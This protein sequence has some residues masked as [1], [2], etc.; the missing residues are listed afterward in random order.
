MPKQPKPAD[1][2][3]DIS[4]VSVKLKPLLGI[5][6]GAY[7]TFLY[8]LVGA[9]LLFLLLFLPGIRRNGTLYTVST[10]PRGAA[11]FVDGKYAGST[12][13]KAFVQKGEHEVTIRRK[14]FVTQAI[15]ISTRGRLLGSLFV[16]R[17]EIISQSLEIDTLK[18]L[19]VGGFADL[20]EWALVDRFGP[21]YQPPY[22]I[23]DIINDI[24]SATKTTAS[25][26]TF[27][28]SLI[29]EFLLQA[30]AAA[31]N[32]ITIADLVRGTLLHESKGLIPTPDTLVLG[33]RRLAVLKQAYKNLP[34]LIPAVLPALATVKYRES[35]WFL[36]TVASYRQV[37]ER[38]NAIEPERIRDE[39]IIRGLPFVRVPAGEFAFGMPTGA[40]QSNELPHP[41]SVGELYMLKGEVTR[42][43]YAEFVAQS[44][45]WHPDNKRDLIDRNAVDDQ[46]LN[47]F[48]DQLP[49]DLPVSFVSYN[50]AQAF[51]AW[52]ET[53]L[54]E[55]WGGF[56]VR[57]PTEVEW[58]WAAKLS[59]T[60]EEASGDL[61]ADGPAPLQ[62]RLGVEALMGSLWEWC[63][64]WYQ[65]AAYFLSSWTPIVEEPTEMRGAE[66]VVR[67]GS[68]VNRTED[69]ISPVTRGSQPPEW[70]T[71]FTGFRIVM[72]KK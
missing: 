25:A 47:D 70:C 4:Q 53:T 59:S 15:Q 57:L 32:P 11:V 60:E 21:S 8:V 61:H 39:R 69:R 28:A 51:A 58:E 44:P 48:P 34:L 2:L 45:E 43:A 13:T 63:V 42:D 23:S 68:W 66:V 26:A 24:Y 5:K 1:E 55:A 18:E 37:L 72:V 56:E 64:T 27:D 62:G 12:P 40:S 9:G 3:E 10:V 7:L 6:P 41:A 52:F 31:D 36:E 14:Y 35:D 16:P 65:P 46:Y 49:G 19:I 33:I 17:R 67:G 22:L 29:D 54:P 30:L 50:A 38:Y 20:S 71:P